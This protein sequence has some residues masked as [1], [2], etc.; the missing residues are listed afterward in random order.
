VKLLVLPVRVN[1][2]SVCVDHVP[3]ESRPP[4]EEPAKLAW[5][6]AREGSVLGVPVGLPVVVVV[7]VE[8]VLVEVVLVDVSVVDVETADPVFSGYLMPLDPQLPL[9]GASIG[10]KVPSIKEPFT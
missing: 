4:V 6:V 9:S 10:T 1:V 8:T 5:I 7:V 3:R 2:A